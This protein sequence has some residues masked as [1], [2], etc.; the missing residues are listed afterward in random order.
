LLEEIV[1]GATRDMEEH[2]KTERNPRTKL[3]SVR[4]ELDKLISGWNSN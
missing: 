3:L 2:E 4:D 1:D